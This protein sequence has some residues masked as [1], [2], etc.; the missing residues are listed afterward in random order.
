M[1]KLQ[2]KI[3]W[4]N[5]AKWR[6]NRRGTALLEFVFAV[7]FLGFL[8]GL[9]FFFGWA[10]MNAQT[11]RVGARYTAWR[12]VY[13][14]APTEATVNDYC[15]EGRATPVTIGVR[16]LLGAP[17]DSFQALVSSSRPKAGDL[18]DELHKEDGFPE[19]KAVNIS[20]EFPSTVAFYRQFVGS[21]LNRHSV[22]NPMWGTPASNLGGDLW[23][24][25]IKTLYLVDLD[26][27]LTATPIA[28][29]LRTLYLGRW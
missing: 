22:D 19:G 4:R 6:R 15:M 10:M 9:I 29:S 1:R 11:V 23:G 27:R 25:S 8:I 5:L 21:I 13:T 20:A 24:Q 17:F 18:A 28:N 3:Q 16:G 2:Q 12:A 26:T 14:E 7:P